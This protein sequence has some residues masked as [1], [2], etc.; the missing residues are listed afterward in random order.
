[1]I[2]KSNVLASAVAVLLLANLALAALVVDTRM[3]AES[4]ETRARRLIEEESAE[5]QAAS[6]QAVAELQAASASFSATAPEVAELRNRL[7]QLEQDVFGL[8]Q[9]PLGLD[10]LKGDLG[11]LEDDLDSLR[12]CVNR[13][14]TALQFEG[15]LP[16]C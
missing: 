7:D 6:D 13:L 12:T 11:E 9:R 16:R 1:M 14:I 3:R 5:V 10:S 8:G 15:F 2:G 4:M